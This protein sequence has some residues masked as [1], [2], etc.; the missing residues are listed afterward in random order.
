MHIVALSADPPET[1]A[2]RFR[3][4]GH[5]HFPVLSD[6][7]NKVA[8]QYGVY[9]PAVGDRGDD[10]KH[11]TF[12]VDRDGIVQWAYVGDRPFTDIDALLA[13][14]DGLKGPSSR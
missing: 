11:G 2:A 4:Y 13:A 3:Q 8:E 12:V 5:F 6:P 9:T 14:V 1:T 7:D 10:L